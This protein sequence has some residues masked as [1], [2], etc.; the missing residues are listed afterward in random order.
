MSSLQLKKDV[1]FRRVVDEAVV[2]RQKEAEVLVLNDLGGRVLELIGTRG[3]EHSVEEML[4]I[5]EQEYDVEPDRLAQD[6][7]AFLTE[8]LERG[9]LEGEL[10]S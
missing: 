6:V 2:L 4:A 5:L 7:T 9:V 8:L 10:G 1:R 3:D